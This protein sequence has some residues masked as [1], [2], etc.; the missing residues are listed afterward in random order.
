MIYQDIL[1]NTRNLLALLN[2][3]YWCNNEEEKLSSFE[4]NYDSYGQQIVPAKNTY[5]AEPQ[6]VYGIDNAVKVECLDNSFIV[7]NKDGSVIEIT[8]DAIN[9]NIRT[10]VVKQEMVVQVLVFH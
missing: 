5:Y 7:L 8:E 4:Y 10:R 9:E 2:V 3:N 1:E 6:V